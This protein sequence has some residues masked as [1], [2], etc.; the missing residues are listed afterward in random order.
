M[1]EMGDSYITT[2]HF[3]LSILK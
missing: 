2:E 3:F 1:K